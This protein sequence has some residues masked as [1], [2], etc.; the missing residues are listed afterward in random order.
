VRYR[1]GD[2][3]VAAYKRALNEYNSH[4]G[5][6]GDGDSGADNGPPD[7]SS[8]GI[9]DQETPQFQ[10]L[11]GHTGYE[12]D[13]EK[14]F[15]FRPRKKPKETTMDTLALA[16]R[17]LER[18]QRM[19][20]RAEEIA[21]RNGVEPPVGNVVA[22]VKHYTAGPRIEYSF[23]A[24]RTELGWHVT[25]RETGVM[26]WDGLNEFA[27]ESTLYVVTGWDSDR[28]RAAAHPVMAKAEQGTE[29]GS[30]DLPLTG[31]RYCVRGSGDEVDVVEEVYVMGDLVRT[32]IV[33][34]FAGDEGVSRQAS[35]LADTLNERQQ[36][37]TITPA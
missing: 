15:T 2:P 36:G 32:S 3:D 26:S 8:F 18:A 9:S 14:S 7:P 1:S 24:I 17:N 23:A 27:D 28:S 31:A 29:T 6:S 4:W 21:A 10:D 11:V 37:K 12:S 34:T 30:I 20:A 33:T 35:E 5:N 22:F 25:G 13:G 16:Q 19:M